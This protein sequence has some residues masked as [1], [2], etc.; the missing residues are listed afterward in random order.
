MQR[1]CQPIHD[2]HPDNLWRNSAAISIPTAEA[3]CRTA[4]MLLAQINDEPLPETRVVLPALLTVRESCGGQPLDDFDPVALFA[5][6][7]RRPMTFN[8]TGVPDPVGLYKSTG[9]PMYD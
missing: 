5:E 7:N 3:G 1:G 4:E 2:T 9:T 8:P 6:D